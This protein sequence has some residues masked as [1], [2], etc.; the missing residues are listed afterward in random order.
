M[1]ALWNVWILSLVFLTTCS[2]PCAF[3]WYLLHDLLLWN[4]WY[5]IRMEYCFISCLLTILTVIPSPVQLFTPFCKSRCV[6]SSPTFQFLYDGIIPHVHVSYFIAVFLHVRMHVEFTISR[7]AAYF[8]SC[9]WHWRASC[10]ST[11]WGWSEVCSSI[12]SGKDTV[13]TVRTMSGM[14]L[15]HRF[16]QRNED[17]GAVVRGMRV[18]RGSSLTVR[19]RWKG[20]NVKAIEWSMFPSCWI[21]SNMTGM[22]NKWDRCT[23]NA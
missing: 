1:T 15:I 9:C 3:I 13:G 14:L 20:V 16:L 19:R 7:F 21:L 5:T 2:V 10:S 11:T 8:T 6:H 12:H 17:V 18:V 23:E 22:K 4:F